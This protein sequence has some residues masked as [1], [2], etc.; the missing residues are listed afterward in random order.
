MPALSPAI[1]VD[2]QGHTLAW[3]LAEGLDPGTQAE[4]EAT[5]RVGPVLEDLFVTSEASAANG[6]G[7]ILDS[8][9]TRIQVRAK[10]DYLRYLPELYEQDELMGRF[11]MLFESFWA[12]IETQIDAID[13]YFEPMMTPTRMLSWL[14]SWLGINLDE[15]LPEERQRRLI[16][17]AASLRRRRGTK[18]ALREY[19]EIY[20]GGS[21]QIVEHR[22]TNLILGP[23][24][25]LGPGVALGLDNHP[26]MFTVIVRLP[27]GWQDGARGDER[28]LRRLLESIID[29]EKPAH[30]A[31]TLRIKTPQEEGETS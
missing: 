25:Q 30:T 8:A 24:S 17:R 28:S 31:Y 12:P 19:L 3:S 22:A 14:A 9:S 18:V 27:H 1:E 10:G 2:D 29:A 13:N 21:V 5:A 16:R 6:D 7:R 4:F 23:D 15:R 11:L 26:H 20:S